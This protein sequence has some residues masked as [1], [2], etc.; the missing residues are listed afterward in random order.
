[1]RLITDSSP[2]GAVANFALEICVYQSVFI[3]R[4]SDYFSES[5]RRAASPQWLTVNQFLPA[6][7]I[8]LTA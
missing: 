5:F 7:F 6:S 1:M 3:K 2:F 4:L 8:I